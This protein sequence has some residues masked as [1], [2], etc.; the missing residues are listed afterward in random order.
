MNLLESLEQN[1]FFSGGLSLMAI[2]AAGA[3]LRH[4]PVKV[5]NF[6]ERRISISVDVPD[7]DPAFRS[8][9]SA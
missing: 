5:L 6:L 3:I 4:L 1:P 9:R 2:G 7:R 8:P